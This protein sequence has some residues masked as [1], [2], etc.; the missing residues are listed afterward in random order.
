[1]PRLSRRDA[2]LLLAFCEMQ[3]DA[4]AERDRDERVDAAIRRL[5]DRVAQSLA[6]PDQPRSSGHHWHRGRHSAPSLGSGTGR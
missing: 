1:M 4:L 6:E 5:R 3:F 2:Q